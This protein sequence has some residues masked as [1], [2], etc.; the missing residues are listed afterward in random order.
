MPHGWNMFNCCS[1]IL[2]FYLI[3]FLYIC[4]S[5]IKIRLVD[6][7]YLFIVLSFIITKKTLVGVGEESRGSKY[8]Y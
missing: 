7:C 4:F 5:K 2:L 8:C 3:L 6:T 1:F